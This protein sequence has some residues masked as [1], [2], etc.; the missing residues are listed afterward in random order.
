VNPPRSSAHALSFVYDHTRAPSAWA[1]G[2]HRDNGRPP[3]RPNTTC[4]LD[5]HPGHSSSYGEPEANK[6]RASRL[7]D[8][9]RRRVPWSLPDWRREQRG[10]TFEGGHFSHRARQ[11]EASR[12]AS[13]ARSSVS[14]S[15]AVDARPVRHATG[16]TR[17][18][19]DSRHPVES[20]PREL[21]WGSGGWRRTD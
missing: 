21:G 3:P 4:R 18:G 12:R 9:A 6:R 2:P 8:R 16:S 14:A 5:P 20:R 13:L 7:P 19:R 17:S 15:I 11:A 1:A 10:R